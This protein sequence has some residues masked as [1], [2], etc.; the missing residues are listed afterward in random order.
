MNDKPEI[1]VG[2]LPVITKFIYTLGV[3]PTSYLMSMTYQEQ[4]TWLYNYLQTQVIP[5][6]NTDVEAVQE[7]QS[8]Y[9]L[10]RTYVNDYFDN[11]DV[12]EE[13]NNKL[14]NMADDGSLTTLIENYVDPIYQAYETRIDGEV[15]SIRNEVE[16]VV[17]GTPLPANSVSD[18][19]DTTRVYL[20]LTDGYIYYY[21]GSAW[22][23]GWIYQ[24]AENSET[25]NDLIDNYSTYKEKTTN[26]SPNL[27]DINAETSLSS[28]YYN[29]E[30]GE[31]ISAVSN[32]TFN[33][34]IVPV[35]YNTKYTLSSS[36]FRIL[37][38]DED[39]EV[40]T[41]D[42]TTESTGQTP[43]TT[44]V[45]NTNTIKYMAF[46]W[47]KAQV[48]NTAF[49]VVEGETL[50][51]T[52]MP[53][54][55]IFNEDYVSELKNEIDS[56][57]S[58]EFFVGYGVDDNNRY[59]NS[60]VDCLYKA[61]E[62]DGFKTI[63][64]KNGVYDVLDELGGM[65]YI[66]SKNTTDDTW[67]SV[68]PII[69]NTKI[70]GHGNVILNFNLETTGQE[71]YWLFSCLNIK[72]NCELENIEIHSSKCR[73]SIHDE[74]A[75]DYPNTYR[76]YKNVRCY[77]TANQAAG[78]GYS[79]NT[80]VYIDNC[81]FECDGT[82]AGYSC[83]ANNGVKVIANNSI[84]KTNGSSDLRISQNGGIGNNNK[85]YAEIS[86]CF[87]PHNLS[88]RNEFNHSVADRT[89]VNLINTHVNDV[90]HQY[91][92]IAMPVISYNT[93]TGVKTEIITPNV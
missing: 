25:L 48:D 65:T 40:I 63:N 7:L 76:I 82:L 84:F 51:E 29:G 70:I 16:S 90:T 69:N 78:C 15:E 32:S 83:H 91:T 24:A 26:I 8:L 45:P 73:Y 28:K 38:L 88:I 22:T 21:N 20:L 1:E 58:K 72:G 77:N 85:I 13:I 81:I 42:R 67:Y 3:L 44:T 31:T 93:I 54:G 18:M 4:V 49:M 64:I 39:M 74:S 52:Y 62:T 19:T 34:G 61:Q 55:Y 53:Y 92:D 43:Y 6:I 23:Q 35:E 59:F 71:H 17:N 56:E 2:K 46:S 68:Q 60:L 33:C 9:E 37:F 80:N 27:Y 30:I 11:L 47:K 5:A 79:Q 41:R 50:P 12:Q 66:N 86:N 14:E 57:E 89:E 10:L 36:G 75:D 87:I